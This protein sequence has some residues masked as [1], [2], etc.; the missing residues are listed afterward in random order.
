V[1]FNVTCIVFGAIFLLAALL[2]TTL[3]VQTGN[4]ALIEETDLQQEETK[5]G[6]AAAKAAKTQRDSPAAF[7]LD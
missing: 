2:A 3:T 7:E 5:A 6:R 4:R 1:G